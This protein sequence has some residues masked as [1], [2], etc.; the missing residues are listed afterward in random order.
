MAL[1]LDGVNVPKVTVHGPPDAVSLKARSSGIILKYSIYKN[2]WSALLFMSL[3]V[4]SF[5]VAGQTSAVVKAVCS[6]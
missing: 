2:Q 4:Y 6:N 3:N 1:T 5:S